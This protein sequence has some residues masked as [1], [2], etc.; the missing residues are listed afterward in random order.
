VS[1]AAAIERELTEDCFVYRYR[2]EDGLSGQEG[3]FLVCTFWLADNLIG[4]GRLEEAQVLLLRLEKTANDLGLFSE[5]YDP[6]WREALGNFP[7]A[8]TH[9]GY[10][11]SVFALCRARR[12]G[13]RHLADKSPGETLGQKLLVARRFLLNDGPSQSEARA[14][15]VAEDLK[16]LMNL[17]RGV[18]FDTAAGRVAYEEM[19]ASTLYRDYLECSRQLQHF[20]LE[21]LA[22]REERAAFWINLYNVLVVHGVIAL[23]IRDSIR[24]IPRFFRRIAY[25]VGGMEFTADDIEHGILRG[26]HRLPDSLFLPFHAEDPRRKHMIRPLDPRI[27]FA[28]VC[29]SSSCPPIEIYRAETLEEDLTVS[30][31]TFLNSGGVRVERADGTVRLPQVFRWYGEDFGASDEERLRFVAPFLYNEEDRRFLEER[32]RLLRIKY[33]PYDWRLN[34]T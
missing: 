14:Q 12:G 15:G 11:N 21:R 33:R 29:A 27:H 28:L 26:N 16:R 2:A 18:F 13:A 19:T 22:S 10:V 8:F 30:G 3:T 4:Q 5:E 9:I 1:T 20:D 7:Q 31:K 32:A 25:R 17:L 6:V 24:E 34:R 23:G